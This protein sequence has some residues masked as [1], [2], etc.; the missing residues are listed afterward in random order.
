MGPLA[1]GPW[2]KK[3]PWRLDAA[4]AKDNAPLFSLNPTGGRLCLRHEATGRKLVVPYMVY[5]IGAGGGAALT[6]ATGCAE[7][8]NDSGPNVRVRGGRE[9]GP[10]AFPCLG[11]FVRLDAPMPAVQPP[12]EPHAGTGHAVFLFGFPIP[13]G[14][15]SVAGRFNMPL[16][17]TGPVMGGVTFGDGVVGRRG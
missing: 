5:S 2:E 7:E 12:A 14:G 16:R 1:G 10:D 6:Y 11:Y 3:T 13:F 15:I 4:T 8:A 17:H 9:F